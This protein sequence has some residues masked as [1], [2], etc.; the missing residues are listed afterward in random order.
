[1]KPRIVCIAVVLLAALAGPALAEEKADSGKPVVVMTTEV[2]GEG[3]SAAPYQGKL[4]PRT[5]PVGDKSYSWSSLKG[6][7]ETLESAGIATNICSYVGI[8][9]L[10]RSA[11]GDS[12]E[13]PTEEHQQH[14]DQRQDERGG[15]EATRLADQ[16]DQ[17]DPHRRLT[18]RPRRRWL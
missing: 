8:N 17:G 15:R 2:L 3:S 14:G 18:V 12:F 4:R 6:Y 16:L 5:F 10:W 11:M 9:N 13:Q 7:F 1:M